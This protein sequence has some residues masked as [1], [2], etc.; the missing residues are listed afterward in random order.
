MNINNFEDNIIF[1]DKKEGNVP[2]NIKK[3]IE[4]EFDKDWLKDYIKN[5]NYQLIYSKNNQYII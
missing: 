1:V 3:R 5:V 4:S 2:K